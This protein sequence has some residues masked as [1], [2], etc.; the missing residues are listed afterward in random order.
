MTKMKIPKFKLKKIILLL[1][2]AS[3][4][5][6]QTGCGAQ[7][8]VAPNQDENQEHISATTLELLPSSPDIDKPS[9]EN[10]MVLTLG[11]LT[12]KLPLGWEM[13]QRISEEGMTQYVLS[14]MHSDYEGEND[15]LS[16]SEIQKHSS[17]YEHEIIITPYEI[18]QMPDLTLQLA[19][20][21]KEFFPVPLLY[22]SKGTGKTTEIN[23]CWMYGKNPDTREQEY[24]LFSEKENGQKELFHVREGDVSVTSYGNDMESF[25]NFLDEG[26]IRLDGGSHIARRY[27]GLTEYYFLFN[28]SITGHSLLMT[29]QEDTREMA[30]YQTDDYE[31]PL[32]VQQ[33]S[34]DPEWLASVDINQDGYEDLIC[35]SRLLDPAYSLDFNRTER[36]DGYLWDEKNNIFIYVPGKQML[37]QYASFWEDLRPEEATPESRQIPDELTAYLS[38]YLLQSREEMRNAMLP[39]I[40]DREMSP[41]EIVKLAENNTDI[42]NDLLEIAS[43]HHGSGI[44]L[45]ADA[46]NDGIDDIFLCQYLGGTLHIVYYSLYTGRADGSYELTDLHS[47]LQKEFSFIQWDGKNYLAK[48]TWEFTKKEINGISLERYENGKYQGGVWLSITAKNGPDARDIQTVYTE[49]K[50]YPD[51]KSTLEEFAAH[52]QSGSTVPHGT[53]EEERTDSDYPRFCDIDNDGEPEAYKSSLW[54]TSNYYTVDCLSFTAE[55]TALDKQIYDLINEDDTNGIPMY[56]WVDETEYGNVTYILYEEGLYDFHIAGYLLSESGSRELIRTDCHVRTEITLQ[57]ITEPDE[58]HG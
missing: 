11:S 56:L 31:I 50:S 51:L 46:D 13:E 6:A 42:K 23:G 24:F 25:R 22:G 28:K 18:V 12:L 19:A 14:D 10:G 4:G 16:N 27:A 57:E 5:I 33:T 58:I 37:E 3:I 9:T 41:E 49:G 7:N 48:T 1:L 26:L 40:S 35:Y 39:L 34:I 45:E 36:F 21:M 17:L 20:E 29:I 53:A 55:E 32:S 52:H 47:E 8:S 43:T 30:V 38:E 2:A 15:V 54:T 44:W